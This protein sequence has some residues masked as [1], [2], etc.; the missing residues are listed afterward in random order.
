[1]Q[2]LCFWDYGTVHLLK[3]QAGEDPNVEL[4]SVG[5]GFRYVINPWFTV[6]FDYGWQLNPNPVSATSSEHSRAAMAVL[7]SY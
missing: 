7:L 2:F 3:P 4:S 6:R 5:V 1:L